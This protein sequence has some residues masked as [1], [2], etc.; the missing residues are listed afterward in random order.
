MKAKGTK[1]KTTRASQKRQLAAQRKRAAAL[2]SKWAQGRSPVQ[3]IGSD[4]QH[5]GKVTVFP[6]QGGG[7]FMFIA[8]P[9]SS[10]LLFTDLWKSVSVEER[11]GFEN[12]RFDDGKHTFLLQLA[13]P[14]PDDAA[15]RRKLEEQLATWRKRESLL[16]VYSGNVFCSLHFPGRLLN[17]SSSDACIVKHRDLDLWIAV[18]FENSHF[19]LSEDHGRVTLQVID[20]RTRSSLVISETDFTAAELLSRFPLEN[21]LAN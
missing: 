5:L 3:F 11:F 16:H 7:S 2:L 14:A 17:D 19:D 21:K 18:D 15:V 13:R 4:L 8:Y 10:A 1:K 6:V 20:R 12:I 9:G